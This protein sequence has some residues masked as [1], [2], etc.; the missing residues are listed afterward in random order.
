[1]FI[2]YKDKMD[3]LYTSIQAYFKIEDDWDLNKYPG[4]ELYR[5]LYV[6]IHLRQ[7][8]LTKMILNKIPDMEKSSAK[9]SPAVKHPL[10]KND[11][12][13]ARNNDFN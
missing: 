8:Y 4:I 9:Q 12:S 10:G 1:M 13:Q 5:H 3:E 11:G 6:S 2:P 7:P